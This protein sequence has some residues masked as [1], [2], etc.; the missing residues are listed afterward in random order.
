MTVLAWVHM[1][2][3][4]S[5]QCSTLQKTPKCNESILRV[6]TSNLNL[7]TNETTIFLAN[8]TS[9]YTVHTLNIYIYVYKKRS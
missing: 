5:V 6:L 3:K 9:E 4:S 8:C 7:E 2:V 1:L